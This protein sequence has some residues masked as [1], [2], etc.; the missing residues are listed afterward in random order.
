MKRKNKGWIVY[1]A[2]TLAQTDNA[3]EWFIEEGDRANIDIEIRCMEDFAISCEGRIRLSYR[4]L[5]SEEF[6]DFVLMRGYDTQLSEH[7]ERVGIPVINTAK[8]MRL[9]KDKMS[10]H[11]LLT[12]AGI[13]TPKTL[14]RPG[15]RYDYRQVCTV[16]GGDAFI[17]KQIDG[18][19]GMHV[20]LVHDARELENALAACPTSVICQEFIAESS[21]RDIRIWVTGDQAV[22]CV[23]RCSENSFRSN[24]SLGG[25]AVPYRLTAE[26]AEMAIRSSHA[27]G[28]E[29]A[30]VDILLSGTGYSV[31]EINGNAGFRTISAVTDANIPRR[32]FEYIVSRYLQ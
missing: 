4:D 19:Q 8:S 31:C 21:G 29:L 30:G 15:N 24:H 6:P 26:L 16:L 7:L 23:M 3:F 18:T 17:V 5:P 20:Y 9:S 22:G 32:I 2:S 28:L 27:V 1:P 13:P 14:Y 25:N 12:D 11:R 10:T